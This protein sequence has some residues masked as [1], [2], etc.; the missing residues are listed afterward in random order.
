MYGATLLFPNEKMPYAVGDD[1]LAQPDGLQDLQGVDHARRDPRL[2]Q[3]DL[4]HHG[5]EPVEGFPFTG[6][7]PANPAA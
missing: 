6:P 4:G 1:D 2:R 3:G 7:T 5:R